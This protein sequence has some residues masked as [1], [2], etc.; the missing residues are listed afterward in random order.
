MNL[1]EK[2]LESC[3]ATTLTNIC[4]CRGARELGVPIALHLELHNEW[5]LCLE[6]T[7]CLKYLNTNVLQN[8]ERDNSLV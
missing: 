7:I 6:G 3:L 5:R 4:R 2:V 1:N 8:S